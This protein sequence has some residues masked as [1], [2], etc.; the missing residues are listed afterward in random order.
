M[1]IQEKVVQP[2]CVGLGERSYEIFVGRDLSG[3]IRRM[4]E[5]LRESN[6]RIVVLADEQLA[7]LQPTFLTDAFGDCPRLELPSGE[8]TKSLEKLGLVLD[9]LADSKLGRSACVFVVGGGVTGGPW[10]FCRSFLPS[11]NR[12]HS[13]SDHLAGNGR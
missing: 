2:L 13:S 12:L 6:R 5:S 9:F 1:V 3:D 4:V 8:T 11:R 7:T 10:R